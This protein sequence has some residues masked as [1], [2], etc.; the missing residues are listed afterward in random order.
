[1]IDG[2]RNG[3]GIDY[4]KSDKT[5][6]EGKYLNGMKNGNGK[7]YSVEGNLIF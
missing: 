2:G 3:K 7:E 4:Y 5:K 1:M 6:Y